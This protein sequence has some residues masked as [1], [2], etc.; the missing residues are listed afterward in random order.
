MKETSSPGSRSLWAGSFTLPIFHESLFLIPGSF[1]ENEEM[2]TP[3]PCGFLIG[4][5]LFCENWSTETFRRRDSKK[6]A[7]RGNEIESWVKDL[8]SEESITGRKITPP[9]FSGG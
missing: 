5:Y 1:P 4:I 6:W 7:K 3:P 2:S 9:V 8:R